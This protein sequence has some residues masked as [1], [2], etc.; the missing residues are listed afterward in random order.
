MN[1]TYE[2]FKEEIR[3]EIKNYLPK[4]YSGYEI[5]STIVPESKLYERSYIS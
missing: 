3:K 4:E 5:G 2:E 1:I